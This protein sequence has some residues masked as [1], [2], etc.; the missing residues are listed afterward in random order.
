[1]SKVEEFLT[2]TVQGDTQQL[3]LAGECEV[4]RLYCCVVV[5]AEGFSLF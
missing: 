3:W 2:V 5:G 4:V 1:M